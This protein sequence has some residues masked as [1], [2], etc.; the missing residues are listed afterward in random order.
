MAWPI[1]ELY[2]NFF[3]VTKPIKKNL[4][5][6]NL[7]KHKTKKPQQTSKCNKKILVYRFENNN[8]SHKTNKQAKNIIS[9]FNLN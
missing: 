5:Q 9:K 3:V 8:T 2:C 6:L 1:L 4:Y 7:T